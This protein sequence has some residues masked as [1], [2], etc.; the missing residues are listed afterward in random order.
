MAHLGVDPV[1]VV[2]LPGLPLVYKYRRY[3][4]HYRTAI[5]TLYSSTAWRGRNLVPLSR[6]RARDNRACLK[7]A[8]VHDHIQLNSSPYN[9]QRVEQGCAESPCTGTFATHSRVTRHTS[10]VVQ[11]LHLRPGA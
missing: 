2:R 9:E 3:N 6:N 5:H 1:T 11:S 7:S 8:Q 10:D 4:Y